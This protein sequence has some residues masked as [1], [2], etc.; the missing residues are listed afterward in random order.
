MKQHFKGCLEDSSPDSIIFYHGTNDLK[1]D[2][3]SE[4]IGSD[5]VD[6]G[7]S[8]KKR[9]YHGIYFKFGYKE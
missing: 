8:V 7:L 9:K 1:C 5:I 3:N 2:N 6:L 4:K